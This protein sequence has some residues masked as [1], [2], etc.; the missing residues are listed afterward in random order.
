MGH[1]RLFPELTWDETKGYGKYVG[2]WFNQQLLG[3]ALGLVRNG[4]QTFHS[5]RHTFITACSNAEMPERLRNELAGHSRGQG[6]GH[7][8]YIKD[9]SADEQAPYIEKLNFGLLNVAP[10]NVTEGLKALQ[11]ALRRKR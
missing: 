9:R 5:F 2:R 7:A 11:D 3:T 1:V 6:E 10:F 4:K 8:T